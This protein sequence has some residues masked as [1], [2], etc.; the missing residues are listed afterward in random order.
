MSAVTARP[1]RAPAAPVSRTSVPAT[2]PVAG[3]MSVRVLFP[4]LTTSRSPLAGFNAIFS[5]MFSTPAAS[6]TVWV[7][8]GPVA[9][10]APGIAVMVLS[11]SLDTYSTPVAA[12]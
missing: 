8:T 12:S 2:A 6:G 9:V 5:G 4:A 3:L 10:A 1:N 7:V 11:A